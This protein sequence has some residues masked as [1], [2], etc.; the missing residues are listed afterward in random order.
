MGSLTQITLESLLFQ[1]Q[2]GLDY[3]EYCPPPFSIIDEETMADGRR[4]IS[5][6]LPVYHGEREAKEDLTCV[7]RLDPNTK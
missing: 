7:T 1:V 6:S 3:L 4:A 5:P 2:K